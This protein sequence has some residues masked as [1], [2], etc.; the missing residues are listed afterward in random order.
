MKNM[1]LQIPENWPPHSP[2]LQSNSS[3]SKCSSS[4]IWLKSKRLLVHRISWNTKNVATLERR[5][6]INYFQKRRN[7][8]W[9]WNLPW[10][11][12]LA[13]AEQH[14]TQV[15]RVI[16]D[17]DRIT[18]A[19][20]TW[21][22]WCIGTSSPCIKQGSSRSRWTAKSW[23]RER[24]TT[25]TITR[26]GTNCWNGSGSVTWAPSSSGTRCPTLR[27]GCSIRNS[28]S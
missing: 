12:W 2:C 17:R 22:R 8:L 4:Q 1:F 18:A 14:N 9:E 6:E 3:R 16:S 19:A 27:H 7:I 21:E 11:V 25:A 24:D 26:I 10:K 23:W 5:Q 15:C 13:A 28:V 20:S